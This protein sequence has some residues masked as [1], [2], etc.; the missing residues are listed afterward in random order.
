MF[1]PQV[2]YARGSCAGL[3]RS[4]SERR[5]VPAGGRLPDH[6]TRRRHRVSARPLR[7]G[8]PKTTAAAGQVESRA[9]ALP[10]SSARSS[11]DFAEPTGGQSLG[12]FDRHGREAG[13]PG[14]LLEFRSG[15]LTRGHGGSGSRAGEAAPPSSRVFAQEFATFDFRGASKVTDT[16]GRDHSRLCL[17]GCGGLVRRQSGTLEIR[18]T[19]RPRRELENYQRLT[20]F[21]RYRRLLRIAGKGKPVVRWGRKADGPRLYRGGRVAGRSFFEGFLKNS[22]TKSRAA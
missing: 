7:E 21:G 4:S 13:S 8:L 5:P 18:Q 1:V 3:A 16:R 22:V 10:G 6:G 11:S 19:G 20:A 12:G 15:K 14:V 17:P 2:L 9:R